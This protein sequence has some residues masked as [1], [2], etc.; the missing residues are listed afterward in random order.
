MFAKCINYI[1]LKIY[2]HYTLLQEYLNSKDNIKVIFA[3]PE[4]LLVLY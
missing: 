1:C 3:C 2:L 4:I